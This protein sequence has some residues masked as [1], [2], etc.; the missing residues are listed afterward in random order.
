MLQTFL[1]ILSK[2][3]FGGILIG[4]DPVCDALFQGDVVRD[5][6][7]LDGLLAE[8]SCH[9][10]Y[11]RFCRTLLAIFILGARRSQC[12]RSSEGQHEQGMLEFRH[13][14]TCSPAPPTIERRSH[15]PHADGFRVA[16]SRES[17][18]GR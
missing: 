17:G 10:L 3:A 2:V 4:A 15:V 12:Q 11:F 18:L 14:I 1:P 9:L 6:S 8:L 7:T 16:T 5:R 13:R